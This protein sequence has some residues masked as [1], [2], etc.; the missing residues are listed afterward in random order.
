MHKFAQL[1]TNKNNQDLD[2]LKEMQNTL[3]T[4]N[5]TQLSLEHKQNELETKL[6]MIKMIN[7]KLT[8]EQDRQNQV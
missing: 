5:Q 2:K 4:L 7:D 3:L 8:K 1:N 6:T